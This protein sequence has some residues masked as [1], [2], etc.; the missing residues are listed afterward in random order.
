MVANLHQQLSWSYQF[1]FLYPLP[2]QHHSFFGNFPSSIQ[3]IL[4]VEVI[5]RT[6]F[7]S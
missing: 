4:H 1:I 2:T 7:K 5:I 6:A 3:T